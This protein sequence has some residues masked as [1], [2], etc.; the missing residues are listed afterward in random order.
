MFWNK[1]SLD[2]LRLKIGKRRGENYPPISKGALA[3]L[4]DVSPATI[5]RWY[6]SEPVG[7]RCATRLAELWEGKVYA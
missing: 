6:R 4:C 7:T 2:K 1:Q 3:K 5:S